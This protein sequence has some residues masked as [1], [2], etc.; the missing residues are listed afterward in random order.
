VLPAL[1]QTMLPMVR[2]ELADTCPELPVVWLVAQVQAE[3]GWD[4]HAYSTAGA[5]GLLQMLPGSWVEA[6]G[7]AGWSARPEP[8][9]PVWNADTHLRVAVPWMCLHLR[10][11]TEHLR[12]TGKPTP[13]LYALAV[14]HIAG[15]SRVTGSTTGIPTAGEAGCAQSCVDQINAYLAAID[16][17]VQ[18]YAMPLTLPPGTGAAAAPYPGGPPG[19]LLADPTGTGGCLTYATAWML[20]QTLTSFPAVPVS[21]WDAH[22][23]NPGSDHPKG[24][25]CDFTI[26]AIGRFPPPEQITQGWQMAEWLRLN[27]APLQISYIIWQGRIWTASRADQGWRVYGGGGV[28]DPTSPTGGHYDHIHVSVAI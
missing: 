25:A 28:Y 4:P 27:A 23:W 2:A 13:P 17:Y 21:C 11:V 1:A 24:R 15:C 6:G 12:D 14:C 20:A 3:S 5:A 7:G 8:S 19:C 22:A 18:Q 26:G 16:R 9:H 10:M